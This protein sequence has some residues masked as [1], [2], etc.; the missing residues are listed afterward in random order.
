MNEETQSGTPS[1][2]PSWLPNAPGDADSLRAAVVGRDVKPYV[3]PRGSQPP[4]LLVVQRGQPR[5]FQF[6]GQPTV[7]D[8]T[9]AYTSETDPHVTHIRTQYAQVCPNRPLCHALFLELL[10]AHPYLHTICPGLPTADEIF[11]ENHTSSDRT[12]DELAHLFHT[13]EIVRAP[14]TRDG[15][16]WLM[17]LLRRNL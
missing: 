11:M 13:K 14:L 6:Q 4:E 17:Q 8:R 7:D 2:V 15:L 3:M 12:F 5:Q 9:R 16:F 1:T 10:F